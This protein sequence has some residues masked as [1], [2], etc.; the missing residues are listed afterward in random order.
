MAKVKCP[1]CFFVNPD[2]Q[3]QC[4]QCGASLPRIRIDA[5][6]S[7]RPSGEEGGGGAPELQFR[8]G[9]V[10]AERY[11]VLNMIG[12]GG[13]GA[14]Y[15][16][17]DNVLG[18]TVALKTLLPQF[19]RDKMVVERFFNEAK[20]A[21]RLAHPNI[22]RVHDIGQSQGSVY[23]S[24]EYVQGISLR[25][26]LEGLPAGQRL[27]LNKVL[28]VI[29]ALAA[30]LEYA[31]QFTVHRDIKP[32]NVMV[33]SE[34]M[35]KLMDFGISK[36]MADTRMTAASVVMGTP[37]YMSP[38]QLKNSRDVDARADIYSVGVVL[39]EALTGNVPTGVPRPASQISSEVPP[40]LDVIIMKC[41]APD[42]RERYA[43]ATELRA[44]LRP[45]IELAQTGG[46]TL[47]PQ[48]TAKANAGTGGVGVSLPWAKLGGALLL[49]GLMVGAVF[50]LYTVEEQRKAGLLAAAAL[51]APE[52]EV[53]LEAGDGLPWDQLSALVEEIKSV[54]V[55][56][57]ANGDLASVY[58]R[59]DECWQKAQS[60]G[61][62][63]SEERALMLR[64]AVQHYAAVLIAI[65]HPEMV[66]V[67][68]S[69]LDVNG[70]TTLLDPF[71][72]DQTEV[73]AEAWQRFCSSSQ[74][75]WPACAP[76]ALAQ[77]SAPD[78]PVV[79][80][81]FFEAQAFAASQGKLLPSSAQW[82]AAAFA[83]YGK[84]GTY[85]W[86]DDYVAGGANVYTDAGAPAPVK[87]FA[88]DVSKG[89][90]F[91]LVGNVAEWTRTPA[92]ATA[93]APPGFGS[94]MLVRGGNF[95]TVATPLSEAASVDFYAAAPTLGF[96]C[97]LEIPTD[98]ATIR[99][100]VARQS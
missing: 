37:F 61:D 58:R 79:G 33:T 63:E 23:I 42:P 45:V 65:E 96:R 24:M 38:E 26:M 75:Q 44:A 100:L 51:P 93:D 6:P 97:V 4:V 80:V 59:G 34:G 35:V 39:Y 40:A 1:K 73:T 53:V 32:E 60:L 74:G 89:G 16:V 86:G 70:K 84:P 14:I 20:I 15:K 78:A 21:R 28:A 31:H 11:S 47:R 36:L 55:V 30:A 49:L 13:M 3:E 77:A 62:G 12:R 98:P 22:V 57:G 8:R 52:A 88:Q 87:S 10:V 91:D 2:G 95:R 27:M 90:A 69:R 41:V 19:V 9:Q 66:F 72:V 7:P 54:A 85:P 5:Q 94:A 81:R 29:D 82:S 18:E 99:A 76:G 50:G 83:A 71:F 67:P 25:A 43:N 64:R 68:E 48:A 17:H 92:A 46:V 56:R